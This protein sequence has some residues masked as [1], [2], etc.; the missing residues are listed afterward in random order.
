MRNFIGILLFSI[1]ISS[2]SINSGPEIKN[3]SEEELLGSWR[4]IKISGGF[5]GTTTEYDENDDKFVIEFRKEDFIS[6]KN[7]KELEKTKYRIIMGKSIRTT[8]D[9]PLIIYETGKKQSFEFR[10]GNLILFDEC[11]DCFQNE[12]VRL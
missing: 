9:V 3:L 1:I 2:C 5:E 7:G 11:Y 12:Y 10:N 8:E 4:L 6:S